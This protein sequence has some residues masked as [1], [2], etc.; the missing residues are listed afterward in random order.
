MWFLYVPFTN[1]HSHDKKYLRT[2]FFLV[3]RVNNLIYIFFISKVKS[4]KFMRKS[5]HSHGNK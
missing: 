5:Y 4:V 3:N 1:E 2:E